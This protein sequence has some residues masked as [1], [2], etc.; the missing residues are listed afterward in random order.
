MPVLENPFDAEQGRALRAA[1]T[2]PWVMYLLV[3][4]GLPF[5]RGQIVALAGAAVVACARR[6]E[7]DPEW[8]PAFIEWHAESYRKVALRC[9]HEEFEQLTAELACA[10]A[11]D[12][13]GARVAA[14]PPR[15]RSQASPALAVLRPFTDAKQPREPVPALASDDIA[16]TYLVNEDLRMTQGKL[17]AQAGHAALMLA[18]SL[19]GDLE[20]HAA[21]WQ[22]CRKRGLPARVFAAQAEHWEALKSELDCVVVRDAGLTQVE[23]GSE[24]ML[25]LPPQ[26]LD[27]LPASVR[28]LP[29]L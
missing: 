13:S 10:V 14:L 17:A 23:T 19:L 16:L 1:Q 11:E 3:E 20:Q 29:A 4:R 9:S 18:D 12:P 22:H 5:S 26:R 27:E 2:D 6:L 24:T 25:C 15:R 28:A 8:S 7:L 21:R